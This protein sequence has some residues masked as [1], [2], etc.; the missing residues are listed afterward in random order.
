MYAIELPPRASGDAA[1]AAGPHVE[2]VPLGPYATGI[3]AEVVFLNIL[4]LFHTMFH[5]NKGMTL[6]K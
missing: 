1:P 2:D 6:D 3:R 4:C 5:P